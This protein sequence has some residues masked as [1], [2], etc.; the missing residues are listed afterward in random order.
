MRIG[1]RRAKRGK[2]KIVL[3]NDGEKEMQRV[4]A[5]GKELNRS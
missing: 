1:R 4:Q 2:M 5:D 3:V